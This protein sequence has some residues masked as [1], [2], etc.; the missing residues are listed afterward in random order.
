MYR[1]DEEDSGEAQ[2]QGGVSA[3]LKS[4]IKTMLEEVAEVGDQMMC[5]NDQQMEHDHVEEV[6]PAKVTLHPKVLC[7]NPAPSNALRRLLKYALPL[8]LLL[9]FLFGGLYLLFGDDLCEY[10]DHYGLTIA[11]Q[12]HH[13]R[14]APPI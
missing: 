13:V 1:T 2:Q 9:M 4:E 7:I 10:L 6:S 5:D 12:L 3:N 14:G 8:P 11:P